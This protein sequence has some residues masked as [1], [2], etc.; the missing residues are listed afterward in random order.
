M[1]PTRLEEEREDIALLE[2]MED[3]A[4]E[5][6]GKVLALFDKRHPLLVAIGS[7]KELAGPK[8]RI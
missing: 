6:M 4:L 5:D 7:V 3:F 8:W 2:E 1:S